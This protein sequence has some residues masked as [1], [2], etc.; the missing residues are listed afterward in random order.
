MIIDAVVTNFW[1]QEEI[2]HRDTRRVGILEE[3]E[4]ATS[5]GRDDETNF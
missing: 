1:T 4:N 5:V 2:N 3:G